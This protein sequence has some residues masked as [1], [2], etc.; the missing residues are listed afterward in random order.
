MLWWRALA[1]GRLIGYV[2]GFL[3]T[4]LGLLCHRRPL[5]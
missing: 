3:Q 5:R 4:D 1:A 2:G